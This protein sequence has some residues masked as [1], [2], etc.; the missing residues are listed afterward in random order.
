MARLR[1]PPWS[2]ARAIA[3][4]AALVCLAFVSVLFD[5]VP[6]APF[7]S[8]IAP[9]VPVALIQRDA[10]L[11]VLVNDLAGAPRPG[12]TVRVFAMIGDKAHFAGEAVTDA[13][14]R[15]HFKDLPRGEAWV[16]AYDG[17]R[18]RGSTRALLERGPRDVVLTLAP[19]R[20]LEVIVVDGDD[21][22]VEGAA[23]VV[24]AGDPLPFL[25][26]TGADGRARIDRL[27]P[28]PYTV[29]VSATGYD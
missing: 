19:A 16:V 12:A 4:A 22:P 25:G 11:H 15:A 23:I 27:G 21:A 3:F 17:G 5:T 18:A 10:G 13:E 2:T 29:R 7:I 6:S 8:T 20:A 28:G 14:G 1:L 9:P 24:A 26:K